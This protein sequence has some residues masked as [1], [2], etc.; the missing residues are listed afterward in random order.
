MSGFAYSCPGI[1]PENPGTVY[2]ITKNTKG[3]EG[4]IVLQLYGMGCLKATL[5]IYGEGIGKVDLRSNLRA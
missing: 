4:A 1:I 3:Q 5:D 2:C